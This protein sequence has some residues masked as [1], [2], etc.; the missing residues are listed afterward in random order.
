MQ[1]IKRDH[2][3]KWVVF[4]CNYLLILSKDGIVDKQL[5]VD[6]KLEIRQT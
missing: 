2:T 4:M 5:F 3:I 1:A 6:Y